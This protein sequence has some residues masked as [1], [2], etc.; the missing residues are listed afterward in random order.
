MYLTVKEKFPNDDIKSIINKFERL[1]DYCIGYVKRI[2]ELESQIA[3][4]TDEKNIIAKDVKKKDYLLKQE[5]NERH[6]LVRVFRKEIDEKEL[7]ISDQTH[8]RSE[9][10]K[11]FNK[12]L[13]LYKK[14]STE[15]TVFDGN[16]ALNLKPELADPLE[17]LDMMDRMVRISTPFN[18]QEYYKK[19]VVSANMLLRKYFPD[20]VNEKFDPDK[21]YNKI[22]KYIETLHTE[23]RKYNKNFEKKILVNFEAS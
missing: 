10:N 6:N 18:L 3:H 15:L 22:N 1:Q 7:A 20:S 21:I 9:H 16:N 4:V 11:T 19:V 14:W 5:E 12:L 13:T 23:L 8:L 2:E 17:I